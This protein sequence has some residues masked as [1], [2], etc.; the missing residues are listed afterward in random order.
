MA[1][2]NVTFD[3]DTIDQLESLVPPRHRSAFV[4]TAVREKMARDRQ[5]AA[6]EA[7][8]GAWDDE[9]RGDVTIEIREARAAWR[10]GSSRRRGRRHG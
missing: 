9:G 4:E 2:M 3:A 5:Q 7:A 1:R 8:A 6:I 10:S